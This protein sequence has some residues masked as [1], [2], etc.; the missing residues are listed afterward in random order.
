MTLSA[1]GCQRMLGSVADSRTGKWPLR[2]SDFGLLSGFDLRVSGFPRPA[3]LSPR[4]AAR[5]QTFADSAFTLIEL[6]VVISVIAILAALLLPAL[7][8]AKESGRATVCLNNL[9]QIGIAL[10]VYV[11]DFNNKLPSMSDIYPGVTNDFPGPDMVLSNQLG[12]LK[13]L[14]CPSDKWAA[15]KALP[16]PQKAPTYFDQTGSS[17][18]WNTLLNGQDADHLSAM[19]LKFDPHQ[20]PLMYDKEKFHLLRGEG[21]A[22]NFLYADGHIKNLLVVAGTI[23]PGQ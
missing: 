19:G 18:A 9:H 16:F 23:K 13:V 11:G 20:I 12:N 2:N 17:F 14:Q 7:S 5:Q 1:M 15:D 22:R 4:L 8:R 3:P 10:Q 6:L 21:K